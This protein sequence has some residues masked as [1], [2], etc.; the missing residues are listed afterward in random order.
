ME[1]IIM[2]KSDI[3]LLN[4]VY[5][6]SK[7]GLL[8]Y[9]LSENDS[10]YSESDHIRQ[11]LESG[12]LFVTSSDRNGKLGYERLEVS[13]QGKKFVSDNT[14]WYVGKKIKDRKASIDRSHRRS[15]IDFYK[16]ERNPFMGRKLVRDGGKVICTECNAINKPCEHGEEFLQT[17]PP[18]ARPPKSNAS[19]TRWKAFKNLFIV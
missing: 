18:D 1:V 10:L 17:L 9:P 6:R 15:D 16:H 12:H 8:R 14:K 7:L 13:N 3:R 5:R 4:N 2:S 19:K 11:L